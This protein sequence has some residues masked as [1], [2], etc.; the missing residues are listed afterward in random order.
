MKHWCLPSQ[1]S[2]GNVTR[3]LLK[4]TWL[5]LKETY[6]AFVICWVAL[7]TKSLLLKTRSHFKTGSNQKFINKK[8]LKFAFTSISKYVVSNHK[9]KLF[10][11]KYSFGCSWNLAGS[12][13]VI[14]ETVLLTTGA[15]V[16]DSKIV[17]LRL[18]W[19]YE[20]DREKML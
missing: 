15:F 13:L 17:P 9:I 8:Q 3:L 5:L 1:A 4:V 7:M 14:T 2:Y 19:W 20:A 10:K 6:V 11:K 16:Q 12:L 18:E